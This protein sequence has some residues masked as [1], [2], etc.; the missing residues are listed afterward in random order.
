MLAS[1]SAE[2]GVGPFGR[3]RCSWWCRG[4]DAGVLVRGGA[5]GC[6]DA[7]ENGV[8]GS[9]HD[10]PT[11][12]MREFHESRGNR[13]GFVMLAAGEVA[14]DGGCSRLSVGQAIARLGGVAVRGDAASAPSGFS[15]AAPHVVR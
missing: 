10:A 11:Y 15:R 13:Y 12:A 9:F 7:T 14:S 8:G 4:P 2:H 1:D 6:S 3:H 5:A